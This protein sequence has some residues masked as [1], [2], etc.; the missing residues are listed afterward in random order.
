[1]NLSSATGTRWV[2][3][4]MDPVSVR[5]AKTLAVEHGVRIHEIVEAAL[6]GLWRFYC[7]GDDSFAAF[8]K[9]Q[10]QR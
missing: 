5:T 2:I 4:G 10:S 3:D 7:D 1:M 6:D 8:D 9:I